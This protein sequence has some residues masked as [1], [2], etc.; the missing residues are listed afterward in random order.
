MKQL[1]SLAESKI[2]ENFVAAMPDCHLGKGATIGSVFA[3][4]K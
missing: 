4:N 3:S 1:E 2:S